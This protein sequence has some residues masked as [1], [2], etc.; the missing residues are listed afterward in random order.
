MRGGGRHGVGWG[1]MDI[2]IGVINVMTYFECYGTVNMLV[3]E[4]VSSNKQQNCVH[5]CACNYES[6]A[7]LETKGGDASAS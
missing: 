7:L 6:D 3:Q 4:P 5:V 1:G 2:A